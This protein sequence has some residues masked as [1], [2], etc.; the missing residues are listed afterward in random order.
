MKRN[1]K[2]FTVLLAVLLAGESIFYAC[3]KEEIKNQTV[4]NTETVECIETETVEYVE[5]DY[6]I[7]IE[8]LMTNTGIDIYKLSELDEVKTVAD[9]Q[10]RIINEATAM[11]QTKGELTEDKLTQLQN[12]AKAINNASA[13]GNNYEVLRLYE[14]LCI[15]CKTINGFIIDLNQY[16]LQT[17]TYDP[18]KASLQLPIVWMEVEKTTALTLIKAIETQTPNFTTLTVPV[19]V[20]VV[21]ATI[22]TAVLRSITATKG[23]STVADCE[24]EAKL[25][26]AISMGVATA[27]Y[28]AS[29]MNCA[30]AG[31]GA[32]AC[33]AVASAAYAVTIAVTTWQY[34]RALRK[35]N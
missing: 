28:Q 8:E 22:S 10:L 31:P 33:V 21:A 1:L 11:V 16:G 35:C 5:K 17:F 3:Q 24:H 4:N 32:P 6:E 13:T 20:Q 27:G 19:Q 12:I 7:Q 2:L 23:F 30:F 18:N 29:L 25:Q 14:S 26:Y 9:K 15:L 34:N